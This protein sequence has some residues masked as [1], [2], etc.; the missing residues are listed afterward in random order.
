LK[1][2]LSL[3]L[4]IL[5]SFFPIAA[6]ASFLSM[7]GLEAS[8]QTIAAVTDITPNSQNVLLPQAESSISG[9]ASAPVQDVSVDK[10]A[11]VAGTGPL[12]TQ[13]DVAADDFP[14]T[15]YINVYVVKSG[16][17]IPVVAKMY[18]VSA[19]TI[20]WANNIDKKAKLTPG[21][22]LTILPI[23]G[24]SYTIKKG[25]TLA[26]IAKAYKADPA[27]IGKFNGLESDSQ[28][29]IGDTVI[30][31][32]GELGTPIKSSSGGKTGGTSGSSKGNSKLPLYAYGATRYIPGSDGPDLGGYFIRPTKG[33]IRTQGLHGKNGVDI[34]CA[35]HV[36][37]MAAADGVV[38]I[39]KNSGWDGGY[40]EYVVINHPNGT[41]T[42]YGHMS[43]VDVTPG[44]TV[45]QGQVIGLMG[46]T[47]R[48][49]GVHLH[50]EVH[51]AVNPVGANPNYGL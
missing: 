15:D 7:L 16:D 40:G 49:T 23:S 28:L 50:W 27:D 48:A 1:V 30:I 6:Q 45:S 35:G 26:S 42:L 10:N 51:G 25:D 43:R 38:L 13:A 4:V 2:I 18:G 29:A 24:L 3:A 39:A 11:L 9:A 20:A 14:T 8:A 17:T 47:G 5:F 22:S 44:E 46:A 34:A 32:D 37:I 21:Q 19:D 36:P 41:Q 12:G 31:P 33:C